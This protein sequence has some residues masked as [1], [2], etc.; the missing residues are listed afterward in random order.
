MKK[1]IILLSAAVLGFSCSDDDDSSDPGASSELIGVW[2]LVSENTSGRGDVNLT[3]CELM[4]TV[5]ITSTEFIETDIFGFSADNCSEGEVDT[6]S[7]TATATTITGNEG[8][9]GYEVDGSTLTLTR[10][11]FEDLNEDDV[12]DEGELFDFVNMFERL[13]E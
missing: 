12:V 10:I 7:Y 8:S 6:F 11:G 5:T 4:N 2:Q 9:F 1:I 13:T 3:E